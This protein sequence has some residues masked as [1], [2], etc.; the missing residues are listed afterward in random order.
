M[1]QIPDLP[2]PQIRGYNHVMSV[3]SPVQGS[4]TRLLLAWSFGE[5]SALD[6]LLPLL[7]SELRRLAAAYLRR[8]RPDHTLQP[9]ALVHEAYLRLV[10]QSVVDCRSQAHFFAIAANLMRQILVNHAERRNALKRSGGKR[11]SL[12]DVPALAGGP[13]GLDLL[14]L[15]EALNKLARL[16]PRQTRIVEMRFFCGMRE[17]EIADVLAISVRT[18]KRDWVTARTWLYAELRRSP[19]EAV[20][21]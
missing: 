17:Q 1:F 21:V 14:E 16:D 4:V 10:D 8:E 9:T 13:G 20:S 18:V 7:Y 2:I 12:T 5:R 15:N 11:V 19:R 6:R 3:S